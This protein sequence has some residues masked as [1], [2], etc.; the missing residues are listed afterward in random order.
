MTMNDALL[1]FN[2]GS[3]RSYVT[4][5][6][7][8]KLMMSTIGTEDSDIKAMDVVQVKV[9]SLS[10]R[11][12]IYFEALVSPVIKEYEENQIIEKVSS[13]EVT[14]PG[15]VHYLPRRPVVRD[16]R[17]TTKIR[18]VFDALAKSSG[19]SLNECLY[20]GPNMLSHIFDILLRFRSKKIGILSDSL[21]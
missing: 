7:R 18:I 10:N 17:E 4:D 3:M 8:N 15:D 9:K 19:P 5:A 20:P 13:I 16:D 6:L 12:Y 1:M 21:T 14:G 2:G 11:G